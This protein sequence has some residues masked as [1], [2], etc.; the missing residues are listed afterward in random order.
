[1]RSTRHGQWQAEIAVDR[2]LEAL[3]E[4]TDDL[5][6]IPRY[7]P[8][9]RQVELPSGSSRRAP[10]AESKCVIPDSPRRGWCVEKGVEHVRLRRTTVGFTADSWGVSALID[11]FVAEIAV[12]S[13]DASKTRAHSRARIARRDGVEQF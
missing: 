13:V 1:M 9:V 3:W 7:H 2:P 10:G 8:V 11:D 6:L 12:E 4:A 5:S